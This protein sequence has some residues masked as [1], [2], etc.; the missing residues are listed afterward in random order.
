[1]VTPNLGVVEILLSCAV[2]LIGLALPVAMLVF[3][4]RIY[5]KV[6]NI[7]EALKKE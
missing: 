7:E 2:G 1:M 6:K 4:Y 3:L 5:N